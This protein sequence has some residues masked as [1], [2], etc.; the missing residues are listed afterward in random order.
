[1][2]GF[3]CVNLH[4]CTPKRICATNNI[5]MMINYEPARRPTL[6]HLM[7][8]FIIKPANIRS[9]DLMYDNAENNMHNVNT[10]TLCINPFH[11]LNDVDVT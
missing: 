7:T 8:E 5:R 6:L 3:T 1:M 11:V 4:L 10:C 9:L 2:I